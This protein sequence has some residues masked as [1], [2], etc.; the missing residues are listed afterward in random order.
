[1]SEPELNVFVETQ[2]HAAECRELVDLSAYWMDLFLQSHNDRVDDYCQTWINL[3]LVLSQ[4]QDLMDVLLP[5][6]KKPSSLLHAHTMLHE[7]HVT[8]NIYHMQYAFLI[9]HLSSLA[10]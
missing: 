8:K 1:M 7:W 2:C 6:F 5:Q 10:W 3:H 9:L 4:S